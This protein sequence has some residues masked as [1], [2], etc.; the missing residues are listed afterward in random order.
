MANDPHVQLATA[1]V[2]PV[3]VAQAIFPSDNSLLAVVL[4]A[5]FLLLQIA[6][7]MLPSRLVGLLGGRASWPTARLLVAV[8]FVAVANELTADGTLHP[9]SALYLPVVAMAAALGVRE[10]IGVGVFALATYLAP[11]AIDPTH[12]LPTLERGIVLVATAGILV[13]GSRRTVAALES[14]MA[15]LRSSMAAERRRARQIAG[16]E[17]VGRVMTTDGP[18]PSAL[19]QVMDLM[20][21]QFGYAHPSIYV[22]EGDLLRLGA[23]RGYAAPLET[24]DGSVGVI[25]RV[26]RTR[27]LA[28]VPDARSDPDFA[29]AEPGLSGQVCAPLMSDGTLLGVI[30]I[31]ARRP[32][33]LTATDVETI[34]LIADRLASAMALSRQRQDAATRAELFRRLA[35]FSAAATG[36]LDPEELYAAVGSSLARVIDVDVVTVVILD[37]ATGRYRI[38]ALS[39][40]DARFVGAE[41]AVGE[42]T[43]GRAIRDRTLI[44]SDR[45]PRERF[46]SSVQ[47]AKVADTLVTMAMPLIRDEAVLGSIGLMREDLDRPFTALEREV[48]TM[49]G[50]QVALAVSNVFLHADVREASIRDPL[51]GLF[52]RRYLDASLDRLAA[53]RARRRPNER[54]GLAAILF[55]LDDFGAFNKLHGHRIGDAVLRSFGKILGE[56]FRA[57]DLV[58]RYGGEEF[59]VV[60]DGAN[61]DTAVRLAD[62]VRTRFAE[63]AIE[64]SNGQQLSAT[65]SAGC[66][67][68]RP[69]ELGI[70]SMIV[71]ADVALALAKNGGRNQVVAA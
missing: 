1:V 53:S 61:R 55:D 60:L 57:N 43:N 49:L 4:S 14:A 26:M 66:S 6:L 24:F 39:G 3:V 11:L 18:T 17:A 10:A 23:Q 25:G 37:R 12:A 21:D 44:V 40:G 16:L 30:N 5:G 33:E 31:E 29:V 36:T 28:F 15:R 38:A 47:E 65:V 9:A 68:L 71:T 35:S 54:D 46:P 51:T 19:G 34:S 20:V 13:V 56:R 8:A 62:E 42:G 32:N 59:L 69:E 7:G 67:H 2:L 45:L 48:L 70:E 64:G 41:I 52:N 58:A 27:E 50:D 63:V 22:A